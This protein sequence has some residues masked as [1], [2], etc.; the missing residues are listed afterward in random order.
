MSQIS[1]TPPSN[2]FQDFPQPAEAASPG[3]VEPED[4]EASDSDISH[5]QDGGRITPDSLDNPLHPSNSDSFLV[6][7][8]SKRCK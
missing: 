4:D 3:R 5:E 6:N 8:G 1:S 2:V 7:N